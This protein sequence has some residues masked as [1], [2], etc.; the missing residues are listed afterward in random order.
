MIPKESFSPA[1]LKLSHA[2]FREK[3][4]RA[5]ASLADCS[6]CPRDC[7]VNRLEDKW[8]GVQDGAV[9]VSRQFL[10]AFR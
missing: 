1:Y 4:E 8:G 2:E 9:R 5:L 10:P 6:A 3:V 7:G